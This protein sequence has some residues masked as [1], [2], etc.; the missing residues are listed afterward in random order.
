[1]ED[2]PAV[3]TIEYQTPGDE[4]ELQGVASEVAPTVV[5]VTVAPQVIGVAPVHASLATP[6]GVQVAVNVNG[7]AEL[8]VNPLT[9][10]L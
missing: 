7:P 6:I 4:N 10:I 2:V 8:V 3:G 5:P 1:M 9:R